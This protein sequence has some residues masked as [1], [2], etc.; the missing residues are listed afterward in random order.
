MIG[1]A[2]TMSGAPHIQLASG[3]PFWRAN[4]RA[5]LPADGGAHGAVSMT[6]VT[7]FHALCAK[8]LCR[9]AQLFRKARKP[10]SPP[11]QSMRCKNPDPP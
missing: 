4:R 10:I 5:D 2:P 6:A 9:S 7:S 11:S 3:P 8:I 1:I